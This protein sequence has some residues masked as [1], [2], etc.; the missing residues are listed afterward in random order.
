MSAPQL[1]VARE[2]LGMVLKGRW[3]LEG[4]LGL[5]GMAAVYLAR[6]RNGM[7]AAIKILHGPLGEDQV[8]RERFLREA[9]LA[10]SLES[11]GVVHVLDDDAD[12]S[13]GPYL[14]MELLEGESIFEMLER[15]EKLA[16]DRVLDLADQTLDV[17]AIAHER[18]IVH[19]DLKPA[20]LFLCTDGTVK[21][22]DFG[23][24]RILDDNAARLTR[25]GVP[26]G[27]PAYMSPEQARGQGRDV[28]GRADIYAL[29]A[30]LFRIV[31]GRHVHVGIGAAQIASVATTRATKLRDLGVLVD[32]NFAAIIDRAVEF[33]PER[34]YANAREMQGDVRAVRQGLPPPIASKQLPA[35]PPV[36]KL[37][38]ATPSAAG[39]KKGTDPRRDQVMRL[40]EEARQ[41]AHEIAQRPDAFR[42]VIG[43]TTPS[44]MVNVEA[45]TDPGNRAD[46][47]GRAYAPPMA[48][49]ATPP[50]STR[51]A[52]PPMSTRAAPPSAS[53]PTPAPP[54]SPRAATP[55]SP[56]AS[57]P[58]V[59]TPAPPIAARPPTP[60]EEPEDE[61]DMPTLVG[62]IPP[63]LKKGRRPELA[64]EPSPTPPAQRAAAP[65]RTSPS[66][67]LTP[68]PGADADRDGP[69]LVRGSSAPRATPP[70]SRPSSPSRPQPPNSGPRSQ[71]VPPSQPRSSAPSS[72]PRSSHPQVAQ[73]SPS[74]PPVSQPPQR[75]LSPIASTQQP[76]LRRPASLPPPV[77]DAFARSPNV[78]I[79]GVPSE[80]GAGYDAPAEAGDE[81]TTLSRSLRVEQLGHQIYP[82]ITAPAPAPIAPTQ[83]SL[84]GAP[85][86][87]PPG[88]GAP[89]SSWPAMVTATRVPST[90]RAVADV[91][92]LVPSTPTAKRA[93][94]PL[95]VWIAIGLTAVGAIG[96]AAVAFAMR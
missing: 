12:P 32:P 96:G 87:M 67:A 5:G 89:P 85:A 8:V 9:Y 38:F 48:P 65:A 74:P 1:A 47:A 54:V 51:A 83:P 71:S 4:I 15:G 81:M 23:I 53:R 14:V 56:A 11:K 94:V 27:T 95:W 78:P 80:L 33:E 18:N 19:R 37:G 39:A 49:P 31:A 20:N 73:H 55:A 64:P 69:T 84:P 16:P 22:L 77:A 76:A 34:R 45:T 57:R 72:Q 21:V 46:P 3:T 13:L 26:I 50:M 60:T 62:S 24:A 42:A 35:P 36:P 43:E 70:T 2:K 82:A 63:E 90:E 29:G 91:E 58:P 44:R 10:N 52:A 17:L 7:R 92:G 79:P 25:T 41:R 66:R 40:A 93:S 30:T 61:D 86:S 28:D 59:A 68:A 6:H 88:S 75:P